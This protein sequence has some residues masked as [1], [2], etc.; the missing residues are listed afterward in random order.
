[1]LAS[2]EENMTW[3]AVAMISEAI[4]LAGGRGTRL[5]SLV[6]NVPKPMASVAGKPFLQ[7]LLANL[8]RKG[9]RRAILSVGYLSESIEKYFGAG[10]QG[11]E[12]EYVREDSPLGTGGAL[13]L[14]MGHCREEAVLALNG[15][16]FLD[17]DMDAVAA[18]WQKHR[19][20]VIIGVQV[21]DTAR[22][23]RIVSEDGLITGFVEKGESGSGIINAGTYVFPA[24]LFTG[25]PLPAIFSLEQ[26]FL[27]PEIVR[28]PFRLFAS[29]GPFIDIGIPEDYLLAQ[30]LLR[31]YA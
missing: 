30:T 23:G 13:R 8:S 31:R 28:R 7:I 4:I 14:A 12:I 21:Q 25:R 10:F 1:M 2:Y 18:G 17:F 22:Y 27:V 9:I 6:S 3:R 5:Q 20:P 24:D 29:P 26:D 19:S 16:T 15:D 11:L